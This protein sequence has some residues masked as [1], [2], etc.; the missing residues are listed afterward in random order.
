MDRLKMPEG[1]AI[2]HPWVTRAIENAQ[3]KVE[4]RNFDIR[5]QLLEYDDVANDQRR[6]IYHQR[7]ELMESSDISD[8][9]RAMREGTV[10]DIV[11]QYIPPGSV[12]EQ[13]DVPSLEKALAAELTFRAP[14][15]QWLKEDESLDEEDLRRRVIEAAHSHYDTK[16]V[17]VERE[18]LHHF[19]RA[20]M[21]QTLDTHW[22]EHLSALDH[23]RQGIHLRGYAQKNPKQEYKREAFEL[24]SM[25]LDAVRNEVTRILMTV[26][27]R[28][29]QDGGDATSG[30]PGGEGGGGPSG[31]GLEKVE[32]RVNVK[33]VRYQHTD[34]EAALAEEEGAD[35]E[36]ATAAKPQPFVRQGGKI[37]RND[38]CPCG[39]GKKYK[40]CH[41]RLAA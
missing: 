39:S 37:G 30:A 29:Q 26:Q 19:E 5:K 20:V 40:Q 31:G 35:T 21:L 33:N 32:T 41:G 14:V 2:E 1:E 18:A 28:H 25:M 34:Y 38:P 9:I 17:Q 11:S 22:R 16:L 23:L 36:V 27:I 4:A 24:F 6:V 10:N 3:R 8:T 15:Q 13:W 12:E 7:N